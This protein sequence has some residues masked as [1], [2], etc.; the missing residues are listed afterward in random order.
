LIVLN[1]NVA[2]DINNIGHVDVTPKMLEDFLLWRLNQGVLFRDG[3]RLVFDKVG[4]GVK[5]SLLLV[6]DKDAAQFKYPASFEQAAAS[7]WN[8]FLRSIR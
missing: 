8:D 7:E 6:N 5:L 1:V 3:L 4:D 2:W